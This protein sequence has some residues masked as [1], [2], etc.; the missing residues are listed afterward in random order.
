M[1]PFDGIEDVLQHR[2]GGLESK[3]V[4]DSDVGQHE[5][6][7]HWQQLREAALPD[8]PGQDREAVGDVFGQG[9]LGPFQREGAYMLVESSHHDSNRGNPPSA[10]RG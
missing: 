7:R 8:G 4:P 5:V 10:A 1:P 2:E 3:G 9:T 6:V